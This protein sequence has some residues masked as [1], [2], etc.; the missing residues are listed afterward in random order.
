MRR[1]RSS[2]PASGRPIELR[3]PSRLGYEKVAM[4]T[5][6]AVAQRMGFRQERIDGLR[7]AVA[8]AITNAIEH[9]NRGLRQAEVHVLIQIC[10][11]ALVVCV[12]D[13][14]YRAFDRDYGRER[15]E[16]ERAFRGEDVGLG[17]W[18]IRQFVDEVEFTAA[19]NGGNEVRMVL[20][21][22]QA[23]EES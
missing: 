17:M 10:G 8:E 14:A 19:P 23:T 3:L 15:P 4:D 2:N 6:A 11:A 18:L 12:R 22:T 16:I 21:R 7:T 1:S 20:H 5:V 13:Q 9:G